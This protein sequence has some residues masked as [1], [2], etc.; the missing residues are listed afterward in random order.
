MCRSSTWDFTQIIFFENT[1][2]FLTVRFYS[3]ETVICEKERE[4][5][6]VKSVTVCQFRKI[7]VDC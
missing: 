5:Y 4:N 6:T 1:D 3:T 2:T 7:L